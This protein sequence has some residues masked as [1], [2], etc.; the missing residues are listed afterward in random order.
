MVV[1]HAVPQ[2]LHFLICTFLNCQLAQFD[3]GEVVTSR[4]SHKEVSFL[5]NPKAERA[6]A[7][8]LDTINKE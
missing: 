3:F 2:V 4:F 8:Q 5:D 1:D 7:K 6:A